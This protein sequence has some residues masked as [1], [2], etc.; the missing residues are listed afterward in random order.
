MAV[1]TVVIYAVVM[2]PAVLYSGGV[3][4]RAITGMELTKAV[5]LIGLL[6]AGYSAVGGL[7][8]IAWA[9]LV[10]GLA[11]LAGGMLIFY[12]GLD[13]IGGW[14]K[15]A[16]ANADKLHMIMPADNKDLPWT[17]VVAA[18]VMPFVLSKVPGAAGVAALLT[19]P[20]AYAAF[21]FTSKSETRPSGHEIHFLL[22]VLFAFLI[23]AAVMTAI[24]AIAPLAKAK[25]LPV[26][27]EMNLQTE[28]IVK[29]AGAAVILGVVVFFII[30]W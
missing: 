10:Q 20:L 26:R 24:T 3:T 11:L 18:F 13:A 29:L 5:W 4:L 23:V 12:L 28:P 7:K 6:G 21:Q 1:L 17:G 22:Q 15:F 9:D 2:L 14:D 25:E 16:E 19:D 8:A 27:E 30:F